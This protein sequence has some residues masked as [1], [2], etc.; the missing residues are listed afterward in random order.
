MKIFGTTQPFVESPEISFK[1]GRLVANYEFFKSLFKYSDFD[2][3]HTFCPTFSNCELTENRLSKEDIPAEAKK[4]IKILHI[5]SLK[6]SIAENDYHVFHLGGWGF[7]LPGLIHLRNM[8]CQKPFPITGIT[9]TLDDR[10]AAYHALKVCSAPALPFDSIICTSNC[11]KEVLKK[12]FQQAQNNFSRMK[13]KYSGRMDVIP[14]GI[15]DIYRKIP[16]RSESRKSLGIDNDSFVILS[17]GRLTPEKKMDYAP[18]LLAVRRFVENNKDKKITLIIAG[19]ADGLQEK[20]I[21]NLLQ[22]NQLENITKLFVNFSNDQKGVLYNAADVYT[23]AVDNPQETFGLSVVEAMAHECAVVVSDF[24]GYSELVDHNING[25]KIPVFWGDALGQ[26][27]GVSEI[28]NFPTYQL[29][30]CQSI[31][32]DIDK[33]RDAFQQLIDNPDKCIALGK[34]ARE[35]VGN[36][37]FWSDIVKRYCGL[38]R[39]LSEQA[40]H[41]S[42]TIDKT[43]NPWE[44]DCYSVF[45][46]YPSQIISETNHISLSEYGK[47]ML[48]KSCI[49]LTYSDVSA[50]V[51]MPKVVKI[52]L[53]AAEPG[54]VT[55][56]QLVKSL[57]KDVD[58]SDSAALYYI[59]WMTKYNLL[60]ISD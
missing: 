44:V 50:S 41:Y 15:D 16:D 26:F 36:H 40:Q 59:L 19:A 7:F 27:K 14:L 29:L 34:A 31:A 30:V 37:Y 46:H 39:Q 35:K 20:L 52:I 54:N 25:I 23:A 43:N 48:E 33:M 6:K 28:M 57:Q 47:Q 1:L 45:S 42:G 49:P 60:N 32:V 4:K 8:H 12:L 24:D 55:V 2:E 21:K 10:D 51:I 53:D 22:E 11:G 9:H 58:I 38:W 17:L 18:F 3:F 5:G 56:K 13:I